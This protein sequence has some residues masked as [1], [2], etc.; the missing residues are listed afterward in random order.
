MSRYL[1]F[2]DDFIPSGILKS[3]G[4]NTVITMTIG[5]GYLHSNGIGAYSWDVPS[6]TSVSGYVPYVGAVTDLNLGTHN[7]ALTGYADFAAISN[8]ASP[9][10]GIARFHA[11]TT[12]GFTRFEQDNEATTNLVLGR[13][14]VFIAR[15]TSG[16]T[17]AAG[18]PV[19]VTG[20][21]G[22]VPNISLAKA[23]SLTTL[24]AIG[25]SLDAINDN[26]FGQVMKL[27]VI[28]NINTSAFSTGDTVYV[29]AVTA[30][31]LTNVRPASPNYAQR[32]GSVLVSGVGN[33]S[34]LVTVA[35]FIGGQD[36]G[37]TSA[38]WRIGTG[39]GAGATTIT[40]NNAN[41][42]TLT[43]TPTTTRIITLPDSTGT[44]ALVGGSTTQIQYN[45][46]GALAGSAN[47]TFDGTST[48]TLHNPSTAD[49]TQSQLEVSAND[50]K[51]LLS[52]SYHSGGGSNEGNYVYGYNAEMRVGTMTN[53]SLILV[54]NTSPVMGFSSNIATVYATQFIMLNAGV[55]GASGILSWTVTG[56]S[57]TIILPNLSGSL[58]L[59]AGTLTVSSSNSVSVA[60][61]THA[62]TSSAN[63]GAAA[64]ILATDSSGYLQLV[65]LGI[66]VAPTV[67]LDIE[68]TNDVDSAQVTKVGNTV[69]SPAT[70]VLRKARAGT[71][72]VASGDRIGQITFRGHD[73]TTYVNSAQIRVEVDGTPGTN[74]MPGRMLFYTAVDGSATLTERMRIDN[75]GTVKIA[76]TTDSS[77]VSTG[78]LQSAGGLGVAK[79]IYGGSTLTLNL[80]TS[81]VAPVSGATLYT[82]QADGVANIG[83]FD[84]FAQTG[85][86]IFRR[87]NN[88][89]ASPS[90][91]AADDVMGLLAGRGYGS[92]AYSTNRVTM[93]FRASQTWTDANQGTYIQFQ[94]TPNNS[95]TAAAILQLGSSNTAQTIGFFGAT[96]VVKQTIG[97]A[98]PAGG[99]GA[100]AGA[101]DTAAN[102]DSMITLVN[103]MRTALINLGLCQN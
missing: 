43:W 77:S 20:S 72:A 80:N 11:A 12:Q 10:A 51:I 53:D 13:D 63:P 69:D 68:H 50:S 75:A 33:G 90:A 25:V 74:D 88:T 55:G 71:T 100:T 35:P 96:P 101:Y 79:A 102:R 3:S 52:S 92:T 39:S 30:G 44:V 26:S 45:S 76:S 23:D 9:L 57:K 78:A 89:A 87:A 47:L 4:P 27:G 86:L 34:L 24:P 18:T 103:N 37:T 41:T 7:F 36:T 5:S 48:V 94:V 84:A 62:I 16:S 8:P 38:S 85:L 99:T 17:I 73:G 22:S 54:Q 40:F 1:L 42:G 66:G 6:T 81:S 15:N 46:S 58:P 21:T 29:S 65:R 14:S 32:I 95:T 91:L 59:G 49:S 93:L 70:F 19:Y 82:Q 56:S 60:D 31:V 64:S 28:Q 61:H 2:G 67:G 97:A 83:E 98:A